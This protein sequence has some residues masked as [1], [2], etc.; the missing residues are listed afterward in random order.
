M[1]TIVG[2]STAVS[3]TAA[4]EPAPSATLL[5]RNLAMLGARSRRAAEAIRRA[6]PR[7]GLCLQF[8]PDGGL[9]GMLD[10]RRLGSARQP[11]Q[12]GERWAAGVDIKSAAAFV[13][14]GFGL[15]HH[16]AAL[17]RR[18][19][20]SGVV[21][22]FEPD[23]GLL[24][25]V[26]ERV[27]CSAWLGQGVALVTEAEDP[28][29]VSAGLAGFEGFVAAGVEV[30]AHPASEARLAPAVGAFTTGLAKVVGALRTHIITTM[31]QTDVTIR[32]ALMNLDV[33]AAR[34]GAGCGIAEL[35]GLGAG[36][37]GIVV[38]AGP[39]LA[40]NL[41]LLEDPRVRERC[42]IVAVQTV[43]KPMLARGIK[44]HLVVALDYHEI[45]KR[46]YEGLTAREVEGVTLVAEPKANAVIT[47]SFPGGVRM[48]EDDFLSE[49]LGPGLAPP[50]GKIKPGATVAH[51]A[52]SLA[53]HVG[54]DPV[55]LMGQD[56]GFTDGQY[57]AAGAAIHD[58]WAPELN[59][60]NTLEKM[61]WERIVRMR[62][63]L[64][65]ATDDLGRA[66][67]TDDQMATY[68]EQFEREFAA[69]TARGLQVIDAT[70]GGVRKAH[71]ET[72]TLRAALDS[73]VLGLA[74]MEPWPMAPAAGALEA[75]R[76]RAVRDR[77]ARVRRD[78]QRVGSL[79]SKTRGHLE[80]MLKHHH[81]TARV[82]HLI[83]KTDACREEVKTLL[84]AWTLVQKLNQTGAFKRFRADRAI[85]LDEA[86]TPLEVQRRQIERDVENV[87][88]LKDSAE[89]LND[90]LGAAA[91]VF[92]GKPRRVRDVTPPTEEEALGGATAGAAHRAAV[93]FLGVVVG[94]GGATRRSFAGRSALGLMLSRLSRCERVRRW[95]VMSDE[96]DAAREIVERARLNAR[97]DV[98]DAGRETHPRWEAVRASRRLAR[99]CWRGAPGGL[100]A[101]DEVFAAPMI[102][103]VLG[104]RGGEAAL[105]VGADWA[106]VDP[107]LCD[108]TAARLAENPQA[109]PLAFT[110]APPGLAGLALSRALL[111][112]LAEG[113]RRGDQG[114]S[115]GALLRY[116]PL[117]PRHD[118]IAKPW[119]V[120]IDAP[121]RG[122]ARRYIPDDAA[123]SAMMAAAFAADGLDLERCSAAEIVAAL[124]CYSEKHPPSA[125]AWITLE[126]IG[127]LGEIMD[128][129]LAKR[130][131]AEACDTGADPVITLRA[132]TPMG[133]AMDHPAWAELIG[134][135]RRLGLT[136]H[137]RTA[138]TG[139]GAAD[140]VIAAGVDTV[141]VDLFAAEAGLDAVLR[142]GPGFEAAAL[143]LD[144]LIA[145]PRDAQ[146]WWVIPR[147]TRRDEVYAQV[148]AFHAR[149]LVLAG[150]AAL[151]PLE[152]PM[153]GARIQPLGKPIAAARRDWRSRL[154]VHCDGSV[155]ADERARDAGGI[156]ADLKGQSLGEGWT[157]LMARR[158]ASWRAG[159]DDH[160]DLWTGW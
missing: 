136:T 93:T 82:N 116:T 1:S 145:R 69:D 76:A 130:M 61:E 56:L 12:E 119:C 66:V 68:L 36:R 7:E 143:N 127:P 17:V 141:S 158:Y 135:A 24:R 152:R 31:V 21:A 58:V 125:P 8:A 64:Q 72:M 97:V 46:F 101:Y 124:E 160:P 94:L 49:L 34:S 48:A 140:Q 83:G 73:F 157:A 106:L 134:A 153:L 86:M 154:L 144:Q 126:V 105:V 45:S 84:P 67:Y 15:G 5:E 142:G 100:T 6:Q 151:D 138:L 57:Y 16:I 91:G 156:A 88:W 102:S 117:K 71:T 146:P 22:V 55:I 75:G 96:P 29:A 32:N 118:P 98:V 35:A 150:A 18:L 43:L 25:A 90:V 128:T 131:I 99:E 28:T 4:A 62:G 107:V 79:S 42:V 80:E 87:R 148:E 85:G 147:L 89:V 20:R 33:Y 51:L 103:R 60:F 47:Q 132:G 92:E 110:Q 104:E 41:A 81:D 14:L 139:A 9:T 19:K 26:L 137:L 11:I 40:R 52:Y 120:S 109:N 155:P 30:I 44:P 121:V 10:G 27:D 13:V 70:E 59:A 39:S 23:A 113:Q 3:A 37:A 50:L 114:A 123:G 63:N 111:D 133:D 159:G 53:R 115:I 129:S 112:E 95:V 65:R 38:S 77:L 78:V 2:M 149:A 108:E 74:P 122:S 54:C